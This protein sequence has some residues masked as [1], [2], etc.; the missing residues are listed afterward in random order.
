MAAALG[1]L[2]V[3][4]FEQ[5]YT[6]EQ[7]PY[8]LNIGLVR[9]SKLSKRNR[10]DCGIAAEWV[11]DAMCDSDRASRVGGL[12]PTC[13]LSFLRLAHPVPDLILTT[14]RQPILDILTRFKTFRYGEKKPYH[15]YGFGQ[16][17]RKQPGATIHS[18]FQGLIPMLLDS[19]DGG[20]T[21]S[22]TG[23]GEDAEI[24]CASCSMRWMR[25]GLS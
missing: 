23:S 24:L 6:D 21:D 5:L 16:A 11:V 13:G 20:R 15:E 14:C 22:L 7:K 2:S 25:V 3:E 9:Q 19:K 1:F 17:I 18:V 4:Q 10:Y 8:R 12:P